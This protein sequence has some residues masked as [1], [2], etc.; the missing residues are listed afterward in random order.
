MQTNLI[1]AELAA[2]AL[3]AIEGAINTIEEKLNF[4]IDLSKDERRNLSAMG[5]RTH[6]F[7]VKALSI[8]TNHDEILPRSFDVEEFRRD[9]TLYDV[10]KQLMRRISPLMDKLDDTALAAGHDAYHQALDV[11]GYAKAAGKG[12]GLDELLAEM[13]SQF[14]RRKRAVAADPVEA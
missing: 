11:Y 5:D 8:A 4:L 1:S 9:L 3:T 2:D 6:S 7:T 13:K 10:L 14:S 12:L